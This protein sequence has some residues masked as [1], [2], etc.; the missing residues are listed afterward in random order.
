ML[1]L[2]GA[3]SSGNWFFT[4]NVPSTTVAGDEPPPAPISDT[5]VTSSEVNPKW[6]FSSSRL[7]IDVRLPNGRSAV[8][9]G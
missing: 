5:P 2:C 6:M 4:A 9:P 7:F 1:V 3:L 8:S